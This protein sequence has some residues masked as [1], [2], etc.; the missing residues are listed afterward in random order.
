[1]KYQSFFFT[2]L[3]IASLGFSSCFELPRY[4]GDSCTEFEEAMNHLMGALSSRRLGCTQYINSTAFAKVISNCD[5]GRSK[6]YAVVD[7]Y[8]TG[9]GSMP[10]ACE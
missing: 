8:C 2:L 3:L 1:M 7:V 9:Y 5:D 6:A 10:N 4:A